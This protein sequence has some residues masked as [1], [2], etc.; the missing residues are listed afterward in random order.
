MSPWSDQSCWLGL[1]TW[2]KITLSRPPKLE[3]ADEDEQREQ[4]AHDEAAL[5]GELPTGW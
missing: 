5:R 3:N 4:K 1:L 2:L